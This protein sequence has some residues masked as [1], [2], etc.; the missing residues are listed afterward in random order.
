MGICI[1]KFKE[2][3]QGAK[4]SVGPYKQ[5]PVEACS[6]TESN[7]SKPYQKKKESCGP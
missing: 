6:I 5:A 1:S 4:N 3:V 7:I 2:A